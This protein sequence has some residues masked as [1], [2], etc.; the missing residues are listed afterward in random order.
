ML[1]I[2]LPVIRCG[3]IQT[4]SQNPSISNDSVDQATVYLLLAFVLGPLQLKWSSGEAFAFGT[5]DSGLISSW[6]EPMTLKCVFPSSLP[7]AQH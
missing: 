5:V 4:S 7:D 2:Y 6:V 3:L 1:V